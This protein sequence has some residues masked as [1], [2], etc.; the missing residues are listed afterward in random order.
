MAKKTTT[1]DTDLVQVWKSRIDVANQYYDRWASR[2]RVDDLEAAYYGFQWE[3][4]DNRTD[5][6]KYMPYVLNMIFSSIDVKSPTLLF[7]RPQFTIKPRPAKWDFDV[8]GAGQRARLMEDALNFFTQGG[9]KGFAKEL[10]LIIL[11]AWFRFGIGEVGYSADWITNPDAQKPFLKS[12]LSPL[13]DKDG[14]VVVQPDEMPD[15]E[16][17]YF[18]RIP[19]KFFRVGG[20]D[21]QMLDRC[22]WYGYLDFQSREDLMVAARRNNKYRIDA[23]ENIGDRSQDHG[24]YNIKAH[25]TTQEKRDLDNTTDV[26][27]IWK[28][29]DL[30]AKRF[31]IFDYGVGSLIFEDEFERSGIFALKYRD[32]LEGFYPLPPV[33][34][35]VSS[36]AEINETRESGRIHR[37]RFVRK[38]IYDPDSFEADELDK[39]IN[40]GDGTFAA[41]KNPNL[42]NAVVPLSNPNLGVQHDQALSISKDDFNVISG[43]SAEARGVSD[44]TTATQAGIVER[45]SVIRESRDKEIVAEFLVGLGK[46]IIQQAKDSLALPF[47]IKLTQ[48]VPDLFSEA[49]VTED[50]FKL[51]TSDEFGDDDFE[52]SIEVSTL[53]P[54]EQEEEK[55][56]F[57]EFLSIITNFPQIALSPALVYETAQRV[58]YRNEK[59]I[60]ELARMSQL[61]QTAVLLQIMQQ[62]GQSP[63]EVGLEQFFRG[64]GGSEGNQIAQGRVAQLTPP[65]QEQIT[66]QIQNQVAG[67][68][69]V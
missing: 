36:Q 16:Q 5:D 27:P 28:I 53:S 42:G 7:S 1:K 25:M 63:D 69:G 32:R 4:D 48:D 66:N 13:Q 2:F 56:K 22:S 40:G 11:D 14:K 21:H 8:N 23:I 50:T 17:L 20:T 68:P 34:N 6:S 38:F 43:T 29:W 26:V 31:R 30:R 58:G 60:A 10:E 9:I 51:I 39:L 54:V 18:R 37:R 44:R 57:I 24:T 65:N 62:T 64:A 35:W 47:W 55:T 3:E 45:R 19:A 49:K 59:A 41:A 67:Q 61:Q 12:D 33:F 46:E 52:V 15:N